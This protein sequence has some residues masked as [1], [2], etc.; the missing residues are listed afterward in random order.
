MVN[1]NIIYET[2]I[3]S[4]ATC[5]FEIISTEED[6]S[7]I[8]G[9]IEVTPYEVKTYGSLTFDYIVRNLG[10]ADL[11]YVPLNILIVDPNTSELKESAEK[12]CR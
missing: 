7:G 3:I 12:V 10:N 4:I 5:T 1:Q 2:R 11:C 6:L 9:E 8:T